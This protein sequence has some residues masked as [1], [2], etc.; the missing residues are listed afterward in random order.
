[1]DVLIPMLQV[2]GHN[3]YLFL[4]WLFLYYFHVATQ[5]WVDLLITSKNISLVSRTKEFTI[6]CKQNILTICCN[7]ALRLNFLALKPLLCLPTNLFQSLLY[8]PQANSNVIN[9]PL[10]LLMMALI[11]VKITK[12]ISKSALITLVAYLQ[13]T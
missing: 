11:V 13:S 8:F 12:T 3:F 5:N 2:Q 9:N 4:P 7:K 10:I 1:M 6:F